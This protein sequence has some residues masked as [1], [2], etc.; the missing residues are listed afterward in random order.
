MILPDTV[1]LEA[2]RGGLRRLAIGTASADAEIYLHG[3]HLTRFQPR[4][5]KPVL[6][7]S[8][9]RWFEQIGRASCRERV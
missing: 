5:Q 2:G 3:A 8:G 1:R 6:F 7:L 9:Q 4:G